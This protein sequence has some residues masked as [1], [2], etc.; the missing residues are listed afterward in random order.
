MAGAVN[1]HLLPGRSRAVTRAHE[2]GSGPPAVTSPASRDVWEAVGLHDPE[3]LVT[4]SPAWTDAM[5]RLGYEDVSRCY[6]WP[7]GRRAVVPM[8][9]RAGLPTASLA[10]RYSLPPAWGI[11]GSISD[12]PLTADELTWIVTDLRSQPAVSLRI[13][14]NPVQADV[15]SVARLHGAVAVPRLAHVIDLEDS[16]AAAWRRLSK[17]ARWGVRK[18]QRSG[19]QIECATGARLLPIYVQLLRLSIER[20]ARFQHEPLALAGWRARRRD[21]PAKFQSIAESLGD[22]M[23]VWVAWQRGR[24]AAAMIT[25]VG[26]NAHDTRAAMDKDLASPSHANDLLQWM[27]IEDACATGCRRYHLGESGASRSL[28]HFKEKFGAVAVPYEE[29]RFERL[30]LARADAL[31]KGSVKRMLRFRDA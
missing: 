2:R 17:N 20:W 29:Y 7:S 9:R 3:A 4:Q 22:A 13:R 10:P 21:P 25:L 5:V 6:E 27:A 24:P 12:G 16:S 28:A 8:V 26:A 30:P 19:V 15:W 1:M 18:A 31:A 11:G 14:P 23:R